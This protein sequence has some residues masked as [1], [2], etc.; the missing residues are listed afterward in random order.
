MTPDDR[1]QA[2]EAARLH[3]GL[4]VQELWLRYLAL[5]GAGDAFDVD[6]YLQGLMPLE[7]F[8]EDVLAQAVNEALEDLYRSMYVPL[9]M[10]HLEDETVDRGFTSVIDGLLAH[11][12]PS[13]YPE[14]L[15]PRSSR[16]DQSGAS[17]E[18]S[19]LPDPS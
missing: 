3:T 18:G 6:G 2:V 16:D 7:G 8:Q 12:H 14:A 1:H 5:G 9:S 4:S 15:S 11:R 19:P 13:P 17:D 10:S